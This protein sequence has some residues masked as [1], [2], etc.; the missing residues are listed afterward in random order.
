M[1]DEVRRVVDQ[2][3][4]RDVLYRYARALDRQ[5]WNLLRTCYHPDAIDDHGRFKGTVEELIEWLKVENGEY[6]STT[7]FIGNTLIEVDGSVAWSEAYCFALHRTHATRGE[8][9]RE[10]FNNVRYCD[11]FERRDGQWRIAARLVGR[12][13]GREDSVPLEPAR[14]PHTGRRDGA[15]PSY[16]VLRLRQPSG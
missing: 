7:H 14:T 16:A 13:A 9:A 15:D 2:A 3:A 6:D 4:I 8:A 1:D 11:R 12:D 10:V 5:D